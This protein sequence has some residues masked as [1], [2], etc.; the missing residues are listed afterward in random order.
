MSLFVDLSNNRS[1]RA[2][3]P[4]T[5]DRSLQKRIDRQYVSYTHTPCEKTQYFQ[6]EEHNLDFKT[7]RQI[8]KDD[9][10][11]YR[12]LRWRDE[13]EASPPAPPLAAEKKRPLPKDD[14]LFADFH[15]E[16]SDD[17]DERIVIDDKGDINELCDGSCKQ[18]AD[19]RKDHSCLGN[20]C[21][22]VRGCARGTPHR[23][24][25]SAFGQHQNGKRHKGCSAGNAAAHASQEPVRQANADKRAEEASFPGFNVKTI[26]PQEIAKAE[27]AYERA[28]TRFGHKYI[29]VYVFGASTGSKGYSL[30][31]EAVHTIFVANG[32][33]KPI[34][35]SSQWSSK[36]PDMCVIPNAERFSIN[37]S[38]H[39]FLLADGDWRGDSG[40]E[41]AHS[42]EK[43]LHIFGE[44]HA[45][46]AGGRITP[47][48]RHHGKGY[49]QGIGPYQV[50]LLVI[51][52]DAARRLPFGWKRSD[53]K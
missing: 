10:T 15:F 20:H 16:M 18:S 48:W 50:G 19:C 39:V 31:E 1:R 51:E 46:K 2:W 47:L 22:K 41:L 29:D 44:Q 35:R 34:L 30:E 13:E 11:R 27:A 8:R 36:K 23:A 25:R 6:L 7:M 42:I 38:D 4:T 32:Q 43:A 17:D 40:K 33:N 5:A 45:A 9:A 53:G 21:F 3:R 52:R 14:S 28:L 24:A 12:V 26:A 37:D 49:P